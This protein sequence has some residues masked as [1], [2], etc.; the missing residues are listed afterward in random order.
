MVKR[1]KVISP[2]TKRGGKRAK[3][4]LEV[5]DVDNNVMEKVS[6][7]KISIRSPRRRPKLLK[8]FESDPHPTRCAE[9]IIL[10]TTQVK[11]IEA[12]NYISTT[13]IDFML[14]QSLPVDIADD[15]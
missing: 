8:W 12:P 6:P 13:L 2:V 3:A 7:S 4:P 9:K 11:G 1:K 5:L 10:D 14:Q 15:L